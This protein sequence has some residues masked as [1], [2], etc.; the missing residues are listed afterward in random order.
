M[1][2]LILLTT[3]LCLFSPLIKAQSITWTD[4]FPTKNSFGRYNLTLDDI[5]GSPYLNPEYVLGIVTTKEGVHY[6]D[7]PLRY[8]CF[9]DVLEFKKDDKAY[10]L[11]PK[12]KAA[13]AEFGGSTFR[14]LTYEP[15]NESNKAYFQVLE[16]GKAKLYARYRVNFYERE[17][18]KGFADAKPAR[19]DDLLQTYWVSSGTAPLKKILNKGQLLVALSD[20]KSEI[21]SF[22]TKQKLSIKKVDD[23][24]KIIR[25]YNTL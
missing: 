7:I 9:N 8:N 11:L 4:P 10:D 23:L 14:Y 19:F 2:N 13:T 21:E 20:K 17:E 6:K 3:I 24:K 1:R 18:A 12:D 16:E 15:G 5:S 25:Y 22:I